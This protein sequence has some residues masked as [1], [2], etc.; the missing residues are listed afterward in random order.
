MK[1]EIG[2]RVKVVKIGEFLECTNVKIGDEAT[3]KGFDG[4]DP[5]IALEFDEPIEG[6]H[7]CCRLCKKLHGRWVDEDEIE[8]IEI[9]SMTP[10]QY[11]F[12]ELKQLILFRIIE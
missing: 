7:D 10:E 4:V 12:S 8:L 3:I 5:K 9:D 11:S 2:D 6:G 1:F